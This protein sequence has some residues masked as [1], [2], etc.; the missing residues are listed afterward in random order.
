MRNV[1]T[2]TSM[3]ALALAA[4]LSAQKPGDDPG[5]G[6]GKGNA[7]A[8]GKAE[9]GNSEKG[10]ANKGNDK[11]GMAAADRRSDQPRKSA[12]AEASPKNSGSSDQNA[13]KRAGNAGDRADNANKGDIRSNNS[14]NR[15]AAGDPDR[16][17]KLRRYDDRGDDDRFQFANDDDRRRFTIRYDDDY[18][19]LTGFCPPGLAKKG[20]GCQPPGQARADNYDRDYLSSFSR[21]G[22]EDWRYYNGYAYRNDAGNSLISAFL[23][24]VGGALFQGNQWPTAYQA[25]DVPQYYDS[26][27][28][29]NSDYDYRYADQ[30]IFRVDPQ[31]QM[32][33]GI[34]ALLT[35]DDFQ[36]GRP[37]PP[38]YD[39][40]NVPYEFREQYYDRPDAHYRYSD[41]YIYQVDPTTRL[42]AAAI[43]LIA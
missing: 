18:G 3:V 39:V 14:A 2:F 25:Y 17:V 32:I 21:F 29:R 35:G 20:N 7:P 36:V 4:P 12:R 22:G 10:S 13:N 34:A 19:P 15:Y 42:I 5:Q 9:K 11:K 26:Y 33:E 40:Y 37:M 28:G 31:S 41:G 8:A 30:T 27:Y 1:L 23:P 24:L 38:G 43:Q 16:E 6:G